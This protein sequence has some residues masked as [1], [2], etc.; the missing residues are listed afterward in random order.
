MAKTPQTP[1]APPDPVATPGFGA[2][3]ADGGRRAFTVVGLAAAGVAAILLGWFLFGEWWI[4]VVR[5]RVG[6]SAFSGFAFGWSVGFFATVVSVLLLRMLVIRGMPGWARITLGVLAAVPLAPLVFSVRIAMN[7]ANDN[8]G[9]LEYQMLTDGRGYQSGVAV[10]ALIAV[11]ALLGI[12]YWGWS[13]QRRGVKAQQALAA[14]QAA[15]AQ[16]ATTP[17]AAADPAAA[18]TT[19][20]ADPASGDAASPQR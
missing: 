12:L 13:R 15:A 20:P 4:G 11:I 2:R 7:K 17:G 9:S 14:Q 6:G 3:L 1:A 8:K 19:N 16:Q 5:D 18:P 10:G